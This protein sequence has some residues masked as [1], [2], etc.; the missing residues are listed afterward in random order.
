MYKQAVCLK[1]INVLA[2]YE[3]VN[4]TEDR[5]RPVMPSLS[6]EKPRKH[7]LSCRPE[8]EELLDFIL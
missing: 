2:S 5:I 8:F 3:L 1:N 4:P 6:Q 7:I